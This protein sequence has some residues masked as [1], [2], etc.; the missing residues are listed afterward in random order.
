[1]AYHAVPQ[2]A[3]YLNLSVLLKTPLSDT[4][5]TKKPSPAVFTQG[6]TMRHI[7]VMTAA[8]TAGLLTLFLV[9]L[10]DIFFLSLLGQEELAAAIGYAGT[11]IFFMTAT[12]IGLQIGVAATISRSEGSANHAKDGHNQRIIVERYFSN[13][14]IYCFIASLAIC[15]PFVIFCEDLLYLL[16]ARGNTL[17]QAQYYAAIILPST[18]ILAIAMAASATLRSIGDPKAAMI[19]I[20]GAGLI[21]AALDPLFIFTFGLGAKGAAIA[22]VISR[23][24]MIGFSLYA[25]QHKHGFKFRIDTR[26]LKLDA[27][28]INTIA[29]P[30]LLTNLATPISSTITMKFMA[31]Y[32]DSAVAGAA[33]VGRLA[34]VAFAALFALSGSVGSIVGQ[35]AGAKRYDRVKETLNNALKA[36]TVYVL[37]AWLVLFCSTEFIIDAFEASGDA[38]AL[39]RL[40]THYLVIGF[41]FNGMLFIANASFNNLQVPHYATA[42]NFGRAIIGTLPLVYFFSLYYGASGVMIGET[43]G[44]TLFGVMAYLVA[45]NV[46]QKQAVLAKQTAC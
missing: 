27:K 2:L 30:A 31:Q 46:I 1:M 43:L 20:M 17:V 33:I 22:S 15:I 7:L 9:D 37:F 32:G 5:Q 24:F 39:I 4:S 18:P 11:L 3:P 13:G 26:Y 12:G 16:G 19:A 38:A 34:P 29:I 8:S 45:L 40:Y 6:S 44:A 41:A 36:S 14:M 23:F 25:L 21:N 10:V 28:M 42:F 35:N